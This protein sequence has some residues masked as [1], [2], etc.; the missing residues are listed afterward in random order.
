MEKEDF[1]FE[2]EYNKIASKHHLPEFRKICEDFDIEKMSDKKCNFLIRDIRIE[3]NNKISS[4][5]NLFETLINPGPSSIFIFSVL[6]NLS[7]SDRE[8]IK[9]IYKRLIKIQMIAVKLNTIY[10]EDKEIEFIKDIFEKWQDL[11]LRVYK[12]LENIES[13][14][15][16]EEKVKQNSYFG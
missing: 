1:D 7:D 8:E 15:D 13:N 12:V 10:R 6:K 2:L 14:F 16:K 4:Y 5:V 11:K 9:G 3:I